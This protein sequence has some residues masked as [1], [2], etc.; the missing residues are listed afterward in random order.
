MTW[1][2]SDPHFGHANI[3]RFTGLDGKFVRPGFKDIEHMNATI[4]QN[5]NSVIGPKDKVYCLGDFGNPDFAAQLNG[6][7]RLILGNHDVK[8]DKL[9]KHFEKIMLIRWWRETGM[10][11]KNDINFVLSHCPIRF[12]ADSLPHRK[13][14]FNVHGHIHE[15][16]VLHPDRTE[17]LKYINL[18]VEHTDCKPIHYDD[19]V[20]M[21]R[22]RMQSPSYKTPVYM[23]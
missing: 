3:I 7:K 21:M 6:K 2:I 1:F 14:H 10:N 17:D 23:E 20:K 11:E 22:Q 8:W 19:L 4:I 15:K 12:E 13:V 5:W 18:C 16:K 9:H